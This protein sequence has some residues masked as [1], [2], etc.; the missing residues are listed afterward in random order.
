MKCFPRIPGRPRRDFIVASSTILGC[1]SPHAPEDREPRECFHCKKS[2]S[3]RRWG[4]GPGQCRLPVPQIL[5]FKAFH[6][7]PGEKRP[8]K[9]K[10]YALVNVQMALR[11]TTGCPRVNR[12]KKFTCSPRDTGNINFCPL[13][14]RRVVP[15]LSRPSKSL[16]VQSLCAFFLP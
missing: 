13:V 16:C 15:G 12:A 6:N 3:H 8:H 14:N 10:L 9:N 11:Q 4:Q 5:V 1:L 7:S 2:T